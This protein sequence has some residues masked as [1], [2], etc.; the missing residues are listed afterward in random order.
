MGDGGCHRVSDPASGLSRVCDAHRHQVAH[1]VVVEAVE[2]DA[3]LPTRA[4]QPPLAQRTQLVRDGRAVDPGRGGEVADAELAGRQRG[5]Q[6]QPGRIGEQ[7]E[8]PGHVGDRRHDAQRRPRREDG[9]GMDE[10]DLAVIHLLAVAAPAI[11]QQ[12]C[13]P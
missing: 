4:H 12:T 13:V 1:V 9:R 8:E 6:T 10:R 11:A 3:A 2:D 7:R 5:Q